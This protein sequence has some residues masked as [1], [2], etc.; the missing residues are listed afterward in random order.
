[1]NPQNHHHD[2]SLAHNTPLRIVSPC[3]VRVTCTAGILW[4]T[5]EGESGDVLLRAG[6]SHLIRASGLAL[7]EAVGY[8]RARIERVGLLMTPAARLQAW[9]TAGWR[10]LA[11]VCGT[12][13]NAAQTPFALLRRTAAG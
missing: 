5:V 7:V 3:G 1:M 9:L 10:R 2:I 13:R 8:G 6:G 4:L 12:T 11:L